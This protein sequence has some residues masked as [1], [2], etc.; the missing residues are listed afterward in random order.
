MDGV[1]DFLSEG[2][3][4]EVDYVVTV[5]GVE[6]DLSDTATVRVRLVGSDVLFSVVSGRDTALASFTEG[7]GPGTLV[8][9]GH[10]FVEDLDLSAGVTA[11]GV[12]SGGLI[13]DF[14]LNSNGRFTESPTLSDFVWSYDVDSQRLEFLAEGESLEETFTLTFSDAS[15][16]TLEE[17]VVVTLLGVNDSPIIVLAGSD[18]AADVYELP[19]PSIKGS[20]HTHQLE[21]VVAFDDVDLRDVHAVMVV[22]TSSVGYLGGLT[23]RF[24]ADSTGFGSG[25][26]EWAFDVSDADLDRLAAGVV[27][28]QTYTLRL[29]DDSGG[30][31]ERDIVVS[32]HGSDDAPVAANTFVT[33]TSLGVPYQFSA[34]DFVSAVDD[35]DS[36]IEL[37]IIESLPDGAGIGGNGVLGLRMPDDILDGNWVLA[38]DN[39]TRYI[40]VAVGQVLSVNEVERLIF[41]PDAD[42]VAPTFDFSVIAGGVQSNVATLSMFSS[43]V[44][45]ED[46]SR[47]LLLED[48]SHFLDSAVA[49]SDDSEIQISSVTGGSVVVGGQSS[50]GPV[51]IGVIR[52][53]SGALRLRDSVAFTPESNL[54]GLNAGLLRFQ[55][56]ASSGDAWVTGLVALT[57]LP[58]LD[59]MTNPSVAAD[60]PAFIELDSGRGGILIDASSVDPS[61]RYELTVKLTQGDILLTQTLEPLPL[62]PSAG[63]PIRVGVDELVS[64]M[65]RSEGFSYLNA[66]QVS[67]SGSAVD[68]NLSVPLSSI[69]LTSSVTLLPDIGLLTDESS[70]GAAYRATIFGANDLPDEQSGGNDFSY[71]DDVMQVD[72]VSFISPDYVE[73]VSTSEDF[74]GTLVSGVNPNIFGTQS[75]DIILAS[76][77]SPAS[78]IFASG[79]RDY[80]FGTSGNETVILSEGFDYVS[81]GRGIDTVVLSS[82]MNYEQMSRDEMDSLLGTFLS[83]SDADSVLSDFYQSPGGTHALAGFVADMNPEVDRLVLQGFQGSYDLREVVDSRDSGGIHLV[84]LSTADSSGEYVSVLMDITQSGLSFDE[85]NTQFINK[86]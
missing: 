25:T 47:E 83:R 62:S 42:T 81:S 12:P 34:S 30:V 6:D 86:A 73:V 21:G 49:L 69:D 13:G 64:Q 33:I 27:V 35:P 36:M 50:I 84:S 74:D 41:I 48:F 39:V 31:V 11:T 43:L 85:F 18:F 53:L 51:N 77:N 26:I 82:D 52:D 3:V 61:E 45:N 44:L 32:I 14:T 22:P 17:A 2:E 38:P 20:D 72:D 80:V 78:V 58:V 1:V 57:V 76:E 8:A 29:S 75:S 59:A 19:D 28:E 70:D 66:I 60:S 68:G 40:P 15:G 56:R 55:V 63:V 67:F 23:A 46:E 5:S 16:N 79:G 71:F 4:L 9:D 65:S 7:Q 10:F 54:S 37:V 24:S